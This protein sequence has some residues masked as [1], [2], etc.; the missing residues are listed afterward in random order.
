MTIG[1][2]PQ[3]LN[4]AKNTMALRALEACILPFPSLPVT[5]RARGIW[6][7]R[8]FRKLFFG[9]IISREHVQA[10]G[11]CSLTLPKATNLRRELVTPRALQWQIEERG[12]GAGVDED[13]SLWY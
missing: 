11:R 4:A 9:E 12:A 6:C 1:M 5:G 2:T 7:F 3:V 8:Y 13:A 10:A